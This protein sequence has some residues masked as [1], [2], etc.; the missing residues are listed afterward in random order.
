MGKHQP[1]YFIQPAQ[2][3]G[4]IVMP[5]IVLIV[6]AGLFGSVLA[7][8]V[9]NEGHEAILI[10]GALPNPGSAAAACLLKPD[11]L[12]TAM[13]SVYRDLDELFGLRDV[14]LKTQLGAQ[15]TLQHIPPEDVLLRPDVAAVI[16]RVEGG[17]Q[18]RVSVSGLDR[19]RFLHGDYVVVCAGI[20]SNEL[21]GL[22][23]QKRMEGKVGAALLT[24]TPIECPRFHVWAPYK[25]TISFNKV[26]SDGI[27]EG[28]VGDGT[29][30]LQKNWDVKFQMRL[31]DHAAQVGVRRELS[32]YRMVVGVRPYGKPNLHSMVEY[33]RNVLLNSGGG[34]I[35]LALAMDAAIRFRN[36]YL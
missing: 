20:H 36:Q 21:L 34:K 25:Q 33:G 15:L 2:D 31:L 30:I 19:E 17:T 1:S 5:K 28:W 6:G 29:A 32:M 12:P 14:T 11:W 10:D 9:R 24:Q 27:R 22:S 35:G 26:R 8:V 16:D 4:V 7:R 18:P 13:R 3:A 23:Q